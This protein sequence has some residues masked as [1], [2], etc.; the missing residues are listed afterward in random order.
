MVIVTR[1]MTRWYN[2]R[3]QLIS[4]ESVH[5][6]TIT[7][8]DAYNIY[9]DVKYKYYKLG[10]FEEGDL[11]A[12]LYSVLFIYYGKLSEYI[13]RT[14][15]YSNRHAK[16]LLAKLRHVDECMRQFGVNCG[17]GDINPTNDMMLD[18]IVF[19]KEYYER[20]YHN[21]I[22][23]SMNLFSSIIDDIDTYTAAVNECIHNCPDMTNTYLDVICPNNF[24]PDSIYGWLLANGF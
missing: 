6:R 23:T 15:V 8:F 10:A 7:S 1:S 2:R 17:F 9:N 19:D 21:E 16:Q 18:E 4:F 20:V 22:I 3:I 5:N 24:Y 13:E 12:L 14:K 11:H